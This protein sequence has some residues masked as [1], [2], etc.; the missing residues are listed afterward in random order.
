AF[1]IDKLGYQKKRGTRLELCTTREQLEAELGPRVAA[2]VWGQ[3][4]ASK[5]S[6]V[7]VGYPDTFLPP[8]Q[9]RIRARVVKAEGVTNVLFKHEFGS[10]KT[11]NFLL[12]FEW[13]GR[14]RA[15]AVPRDAAVGWDPK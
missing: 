11:F 15:L 2:Q 10:G 7:V 8:D 9:E 14:C 3:I 1:D 5:E 12:G 13:P 6:V 4:D